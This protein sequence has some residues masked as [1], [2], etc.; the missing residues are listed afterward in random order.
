[1]TRPHEQ[2]ETEWAVFNGLNASGMVC[3]SSGS[4][5]L[6]LALEALQ[7]PPGSEVIVPNLTMVACP[8]AVV[9]AGLA[10]VFVD[11]GEDLLID[12]NLAMDA[13]SEYRP[14]A[15]ALMIVHI[16]GRAADMTRL[17]QTV[18]DCNDCLVIEDL[19]EA[20]GVRPHP[21]TDAACWSFYR[22]KIVAGEEGG[23]VWFRDP[24]HARLARS[25]RCLG[26]T[27]EHDFM[28][29]PRGHNYRMS[30][31]HARLVLDS[32]AP[33]QVKDNLAIRR[34]IE[35]NYNRHC[36]VEWRMPPRDVPWVYDLRLPGITQEQQ[37]TAVRALQRAGYQAR[38]AFKPMHLQEEF[39]GCRLVGSNNALKVAREVIYLPLDPGRHTYAS[40]DDFPRPFEVIRGVLDPP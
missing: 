14:D 11:C 20:H 36:P 7:L 1:M 16:Y 33:N 38:H 26:F 27:E 31:A 6:H 4:A 21:Q 34:T 25:L 30:D 19:A 3:C 5:A 8:R 18:V 13:F 24:D 12:Q 15:C 10:P 40:A 32:L 29:A 28:H 37:T 35:A 39:K 17:Q 22:N 23:A 9:L 2:L